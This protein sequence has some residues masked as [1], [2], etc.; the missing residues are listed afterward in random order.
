MISLVVSFAIGIALAM[1]FDQNIIARFR[2]TRTLEGEALIRILKKSKLYDDIKGNQRSISNRS[3]NRNR[4]NVLALEQA[5]ARG[6][7]RHVLPLRSG[8]KVPGSGVER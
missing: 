1:W 5:R 6:N 3:G 2:P 7:G 8:S 4:D